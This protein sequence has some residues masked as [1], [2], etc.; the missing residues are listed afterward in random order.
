M[1]QQITSLKTQKVL[2]LCSGIGGFTLGHLIS[3][4]FQTVAFCEI[5]SYCQQLLHLQFPNIPII[6]DIHDITVKSLAGVGVGEIDGI[7]AGLPCPP[8]SLAGKQQASKDERNLFGEFFRILR[9]VRPQWAIV[10][11]VPGLITAEGGEFCYAVLW[12]FAQ[13]GFDV[14]WGALSASQVGAVH[15]RE[16][17]WIIAT[18]SQSRRRGTSWSQ[19]SPCGTNA[20]SVG[21][22]D[23][24]Y[25]NCKR[26]ER[27][28]PHSVE[29]T[30][31]SQ[32]HRCGSGGLLQ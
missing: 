24:A 12:E 21:G 11:N 25:T 15:K 10:E 3:G 28:Q 5:N 17:V 7:I 31:L 19:Y 8:F 22:G 29:Q 16:R 4:G 32:T 27:W 9:Q 30:A 20:A 18:H 6:S 13:M 26:L 23:N 2:D 1:T 14:Q